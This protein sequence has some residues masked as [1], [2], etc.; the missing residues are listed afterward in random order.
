MKTFEEVNAEI[1][2]LDLD[3]LPSVEGNNM[4]GAVSMSPEQLGL[5]YKQIRPILVLLNEM[6]FLPAK[7]KALLNKF[8]EYVDAFTGITTMG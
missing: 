2:A 4:V 5:I 6:W 3:T 8:M 1:E 7:W